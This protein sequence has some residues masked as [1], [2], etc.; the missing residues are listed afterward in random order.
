MIE[1]RKSTV[2]YIINSEGERE[3]KQMTDH[4]VFSGYTEKIDGQRKAWYEQL[5]GKRLEWEDL[6]SAGSTNELLEKMESVP[7]Y[8]YLVN[9]LLYAW[10]KGENQEIRYDQM[11]SDLTDRVADAFKSNGMPEEKCAK[12]HVRDML[13][14]EWS[15]EWDSFER[16]ASSRVFELGLGLGLPADDV[17]QLLQKAVRRTGFNYYDPEELIIYCVLRFCTSDHYRCCQAMLRD[18]RAAVPLKGKEQSIW[19]EKTSEVRDQMLDMIEGTVEDGRLYSTDTY[20]SGTLN[21]GLA[22]FFSRHKAALPKV[23][24]AA[25]EFEKLLEKFIESH[26]KDILDFK[27]TDRGSEEY[28]KAV[29]Q[30]E[31]DAG[32]EIRL[33][34]GT[35]FY[36]LKGKEKRRVGFV[37]E[38]AALLPGREDIEVEIPVRGTEPQVICLAKKTTPGYVGKMTEMLPEEQALMAGVMRAYT[39]TTLKYT[40]NPGD[41]QTAKGTICA[42]CSPGTELPAGTLFTHDGFAYATET[43]CRAAARADVSVRS[44]Y[45]CR[46][47]EKIAETGEIQYMDNPPEGILSVSNGKPVSRKEQTEKI[48]KELFRDFLYVKDAE[49]LG[50]DERQIDRSLLG[51]WFTETEITSV[52]LSNIR[53]QADEKAKRNR[54]R[55]ERSEVRRC[56][57]ITMAFLNFC[58]DTDDEPDEYLIEADSEAVYQDFVRYVNPLLRKCGMMPFYLQNPYEYL[59]AYLIQTDTP[60]DSLRNMWKIVNAGK[61]ETDD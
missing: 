25:V 5:A 24:T 57:I 17:E 15:R 42:V 19:F 12:A 55:L 43:E 46:K 53:K 50:A 52:R 26:R 16:A 60:V 47:G 18:Y 41:K 39:S 9:Y 61:E 37:M 6:A 4:R 3:E 28:A 51:Y 1:K 54:T 14:T 58:A 8:Q 23:R 31:Y 40:G 45:P 7:L 10:E 44:E 33:P 20:E 27:S 30:V 2:T 56:D 49:R 35:T 48:S 36:A 22:T 59:L 21:P 38:N 13:T 34:A 29:L 32:R 11:I